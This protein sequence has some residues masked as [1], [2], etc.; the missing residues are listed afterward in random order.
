[1][2]HITDEQIKRYY[3]HDLRQDEEISMLTHIAKCEYCAGRFASGIPE[4]EM[5]KL[6]RGVT[7]GILEKAEKIPTRRD[8]KKEYYGYCTRVALGM[9]MALGLLVTVNL[10]N[11]LYSQNLTGAGEVI[12]EVEQNVNLGLGI[13][14]T[15]KGVMAE[16]SKYDKKQLEMKKKQEEERKKFIEKNREN[17]GRESFSINRVFKN[18]RNFLQI[19]K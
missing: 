19:K 11:G 7:A 18:L 14:D 17:S 10:S 13:G 1:M 15:K 6:P 4:T 12:E 2:A 5:I 16:K 8:R 3:M 9:C